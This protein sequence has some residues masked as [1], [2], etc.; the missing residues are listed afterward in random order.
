MAKGT[1][2]AQKLK[3]M[4]FV[5][6]KTAPDYQQ[7]IKTIDEI[8]GTTPSGPFKAVSLAQFEKQ[9][10]EEMN[11]ADMQALASRV[12]LLPIHDRPLLKKRL[13][14]EFK[15]DLR[16]KTPYDVSSATGQSDNLD[17]NV[18][19]KARRILKEGQ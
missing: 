10:D 14:D 13:I 6:G 1:T 12:G 18:G 4:K 11:L 15:K 5:D 7:S 2:K 16:K 17:H 9:V 19:D 3:E 8:L